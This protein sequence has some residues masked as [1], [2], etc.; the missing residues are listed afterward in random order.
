MVEPIVGAVGVLQFE[1]L[2][3]RLAA[4]YKVEVE[5]KPLPF[6]CARWVQGEGFDA[7]AFQRRETTACVYDI[8]D[9]P[10]LLMRNKW[11]LNWIEDDNK[12]LEFL[13]YA[14]D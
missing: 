4:E 3:Y 1:V 14:P 5:L 13:A 2:K 6:A 9:R 8:H 12:G 7:A 11:A 10:V